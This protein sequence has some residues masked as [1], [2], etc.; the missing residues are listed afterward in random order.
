VNEKATDRTVYLHGYDGPRCVEGR[1]LVEIPPEFMGAATTLSRD[2]RLA[3]DCFVAF[4]AVPRPIVKAI[5]RNMD[6]AQ[7]GFDLA[8]KSAHPGPWAGSEEVH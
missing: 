1:D 4:G 5:L 8:A 2:L 6:A 7:T 3:L